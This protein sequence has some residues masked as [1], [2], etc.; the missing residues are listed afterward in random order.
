MLKNLLKININ[1]IMSD[2]YDPPSPIHASQLDEDEM[3]RLMQQ[4]ELFTEQDEFDNENDLE[5][6]RQGKY[7]DYIENKLL[8]QK[9]DS[10][11]RP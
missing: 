7:D 10:K 3:E 2:E 6:L 1:F 5:M 4:S 11:L 8:R 9:F